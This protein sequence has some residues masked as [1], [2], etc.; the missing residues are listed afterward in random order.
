[1]ITKS[2]TIAHILDNF[3]QVAPIISGYGLHCMSC[4]QKWETL[5]QGAK[6]HGLTDD[7]LSEMIGNCNEFLEKNK[8][9]VGLSDKA[10]AKIKQI[11]E[12]EGKEGALR[13]EVIPGGCSGFKYDLALETEPKENDLIVEQKGVKLFVAQNSVEKLKGSII[14][15]VDA[16]QGAGFNVINPNANKSC[17]CGKS[18]N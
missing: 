14:D 15:Y 16:L 3:P 2:D 9:N 10:I 18:F 13:I 6:G 17:G 1:M 11:M 4:S 7:Q 12:S 8:E 5:E